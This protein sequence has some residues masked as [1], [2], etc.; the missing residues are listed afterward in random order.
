MQPVKKSTTEW[1]PRDFRVRCRR[2]D[3]W[4]RLS[5]ELDRLRR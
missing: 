5:R 2:D 3:A 4:N 1:R